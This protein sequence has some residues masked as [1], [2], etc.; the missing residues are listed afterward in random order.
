MYKS[1]FCHYTGKDGRTPRRRSQSL[2][3]FSEVPAIGNTSLSPTPLWA[4]VFPG[5]KSEM[6]VIH[7]QLSPEVA[8]YTGHYLSTGMCALMRQ[9]EQTTPSLAHACS[10]LIDLYTSL[11]DFTAW[12]RDHPS[13]ITPPVLR[14]YAEARP[15]EYQQLKS[16]SNY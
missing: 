1:F 8:V 3:F 10:T 5:D 9:P 4:E 14:A 11:T 15:E 12:L 16:I 13:H 2:R 6:L 7:A